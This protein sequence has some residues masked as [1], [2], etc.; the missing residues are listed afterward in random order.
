MTTSKVIKECRSVAK[1]AGL[2]F[3]RSNMS[4]NNSPSYYFKDRLS[5]R[6]VLENCT[7]ASAYNNCC[8]GYISSY[9]VN[10]GLFS[11]CEND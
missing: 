8:S 7:L 6:I 10:D 1:K 5:G 2:T 11:G 3:K 9:S 4:I